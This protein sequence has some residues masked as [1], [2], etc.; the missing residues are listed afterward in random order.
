MLLYLIA[1]L[2]AITVISLLLAPRVQTTDGFFKGFSDN[3]DA[4]GLWTLVLSQVTTW[5]FAR[6]LMT[7]AILG[8]YYGIAGALAYAAY[9][10]SFLTGGAII[11]HLRFKHGKGN[12]QSFMRENF[13]SIGDHCYNLVII[14]RLLSEVFS[15]LLVIGIIFG[16]SGSVEYGLA[17]A[18]VAVTTFVYSMSGGLRCLLYT[19]PS[20]RDRG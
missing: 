10:V 3:G 15:N 19:S 4:P 9:Y 2:S 13:G 20:P 16:V 6:S 11:D 8:Y 5:I 18:L 12:I 1:I 14:L 17:M 7:A